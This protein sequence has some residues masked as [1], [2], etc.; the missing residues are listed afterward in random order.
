MSVASYLYRRRAP[1]RIHCGSHA[2]LQIQRTDT[3][4]GFVA[5]GHWVCSWRTV[6]DG[7]RRTS[8]AR[9]PRIRGRRIS[10]LDRT[11]EISKR[12]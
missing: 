10:L 9:N 11:Q 1:M 4:C 7:K 2:R 8:V 3:S 6:P 12:P 5:G